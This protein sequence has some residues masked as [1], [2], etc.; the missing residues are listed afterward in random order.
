M[1]SHP[2]ICAPFISSVLPSKLVC[3]REVRE[4]PELLEEPL[5]L[6]LSL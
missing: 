3:V 4:L 5:A 1:L 2:T 6:W